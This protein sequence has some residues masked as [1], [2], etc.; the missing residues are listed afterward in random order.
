[1]AIT[2]LYMAHNGSNNIILPLSHSDS[3]SGIK[4][5]KVL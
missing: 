3:E 4:K 2:T 1:M 5:K